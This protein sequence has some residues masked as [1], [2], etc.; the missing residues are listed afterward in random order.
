[1]D[2]II[3][4]LVAGYNPMTLLLVCI[5]VLF[6]MVCGALPGLSTSMAII[7]L[8]PFTYSMDPIS[9]IVLMVSCYV[10]GSCGGSLS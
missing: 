10:G 4:S 6:G 1:M 8:L 3:Q 7:L 5:G 9:A 2:I